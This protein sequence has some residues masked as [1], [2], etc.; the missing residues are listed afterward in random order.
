MEIQVSSSVAGKKVEGDLPLPPPPPDSSQPSADF[1]GSQDSG[2]LPLPPPK[3]SFSK[4]YEQRQVNELKRLYRHMHPELRKNLEEAVSHDLAEIL[5][6][7]DGNQQALLSSDPVVPGEVQSMRWIFENWTLDSIGEHQGLKKL[8]DEESVLSGNVKSTSLQFINQAPS[9][10]ELSNCTTLPDSDKSKGDVHTALWLFETQPLDSLNKMH[11]QQIDVQEAVLREPVARGDVGSAKLL[12]ETCS[13][14]AIGRCKSVE[15]QNLLQLKSEIQE[16]KGDV[17]KT[18]RLF[19]TEPLCAIRDQAGNIHEVKS[20]C[21]EDI[22]SNA[23][24]SVRWLFET[25]PLDTINKDTSAVQLIRGIS[26][27]EAG[28][29]GVNAAKWMFETQPLDTIKERI[30]EGDFQACTE[31][32]SG[33]DVSKHRFLFETQPLDSLKGEETEAVGPK[34]SV[35]GGDVKSTLWLF[36]TQPAKIPKKHFEVGHLQKVELLDAERGDVKQRKNVFETCSLSSIAKHFSDDQ[37]AASD[38]QDIVKGDVK[39]FKNLFETLPL[40]SISSSDKDTAVQEEEIV[41]G[42]VRA[43]QHLFE[44]TPLYAIK[45]S[46]GNFHKVTSVSREQVMSGDVKNYKWMFET[47]PLDQFD[48]SATKVDVIRGITKQEVMAGNVGT[49]KWLFETQPIDVIH[50]KMSKAGEQML[51]KTEADQKGDVMKCR[52]LFE[53]QPVDTLYDKIDTKKDEEPVP[54]ADVKSYTWMF[55]TQPL[56]TLK[57]SEEQYLKVS[58]TTQEDFSGV[59][60]KTTRYLFETEPLN[61]DQSGAQSKRIVRYS[62]RVEMPSG[63]VSRVKEIFESKPAATRMNTSNLTMKESDLAANESIQAGSVNKFT[64]LFENCPMDALANNSEGIQEVLPEKDIKAGDV[65]GKRFVFETYSL[66]QIHEGADGTETREVQEATVKQGAVKSSTMLFETMPL[67]AIQDKEGDYHEVTSVKKEE[68]MKGDVRGAKWLFETK[69]LDSIKTGE[70]VFVIRAVTQEDIQKGDV[71][72]ARWKFETEPLDSFSKESGSVARTVA[73]VQRGDVQSNKQLFESQQVSQKKYVRMVSV[74][75]VQQG[76][77]RTSTWLFENQPI[78]SLKGDAEEES[79]LS[80]VQ[81][82]DNQ[83]GDVKR[84]TWLFETQPMDRLKDCEG[85]SIQATQ[86]VVPPADVKSTTWL[87]ESTPLDKFDS[88][89][90]A[91]NE[92][93]ERNVKDSLDALCSCS[94][95]QDSGIIIEGNEA[96]NVKMAKYKLANQQAP[97]I[98]KEEIVGGNLKRIMQQIL[99]RTNVQSQATLVEENEKGDL[100]VGTMQ[101]FNQRELNLKEEESKQDVS[102]VLQILH[103]QA[104]AIKNGIV[105][106]ETKAGMIKI[107]IYSLLQQSTSR[108][109]QEEVVKGDVKSTIGS[110]LASTQEQKCTSTVKREDNEKGNVQL[111]ATCIE[112]GDLSYLKSLQQ[113]SEINLIDFSQDAVQETPRMDVAQNMIHLERELKGSEITVPSIAPGDI[114]GIKRL[115]TLDNIEQCH[116]TNKVACDSTTATVQPLYQP[117]FVNVA[118]NNLPCDIEAR[119]QSHEIATKNSTKLDAEEHTSRNVREIK[120]VS[121]G[122]LSTKRNTMPEDMASMPATC[123]VPD[124]SLMAPLVED[125]VGSELQAALH[126]LRQA[127]AEAESIQNQVRSKLHKSTEEIHLSSR[128]TAGDQGRV[129]VTAQPVLQQQAAVSKQQARTVA[130]VQETHKSYSSQQKTT[131]VTKKVSASEEQPGQQLGNARQDS[132]IAT[133]ANSSIKDG[134][135]TARP[136]KNFYNPFIED[137]YNEMSLREDVEQDEIVRGDVKAAIRALQGASSEQKALEKEDVVRGN[138]KATLQSLEKSNINVSKGDFKAAM[139]YK[140]AGMSHSICKQSSND[141]EIRKQALLMPMSLSDNDSPPSAAAVMQTVCSGATAK[142][143]AIHQAGNTEVSQGC[144]TTMQNLAPVV[145]KASET[146][147]QAD[148]TLSISA[149]SVPGKKPTLPPKPAHL[150][151]NTG[152]APC[153]D[154]RIRP[155]SVAPLLPP[156]TAALSN[157]QPVLPTDHPKLVNSAVYSEE[158]ER[159]PKNDPACRFPMESKENYISETKTAKNKKTALQIAEEKYRK[160]KEEEMKTESFPEKG[161]QEVRV[162][163]NQMKDFDVAKDCD[164]ENTFSPKMFSPAEELQDSFPPCVEAD[165]AKDDVPYN[166]RAAFSHFE[167]QASS[168]ERGHIATM[169]K[170][171]VVTDGTSVMPNKAHVPETCQMKGAFETS[172]ATNQ[173]RQERVFT[174][175]TSC[176]KQ[177]QESSLQ[178]QHVVCQ[179]NRRLTAEDSKPQNAPHMYQPRAEKQVVIMREKPGRESED[180]RRKRLSVHKDEIMRGNVKAAMDI[181]ENLRKHEELQKILSKVEE[182]EEET[183]TVDVKSLKGLFEN[184][185]NWVVG[186]QD[187]VQPPNVKEQAKV[188]YSGAAKED[189]ESISSVELAFGDLEKASTEITHLKEQTLARLLDIEDAI[190]KAL[191]SVSNLKSE[192]DIAGLSGLFKESLGSNPSPSAINNIRKISIVSSKS[193]P[194]KGVQVTEGRNG[195][196]MKLVEKQEMAKQELEVVNVPPRGSSPV[197]P[198]F[199][200]IESAARRPAELSDTSCCPSGLPSKKPVK[201]EKHIQDNL[202]FLSYLS[203]ECGNSDSVV[204]E[205]EECGMLKQQPNAS[206]CPTEATVQFGHSGTN[207]SSSTPTA[208]FQGCPSNSKRGVSC[209]YKPNASSSPLNPRRQKSVLELKTIPELP[210]VIG[211]TIVT[212]E[213]EEYD[214]FG[215]KIVTSKSSKTVTKQS[216]SKTS[217]T[218]EA[219]STPTRYGVTASPLLRR[220]LHSTGEDYQPNG[221]ANEAGVVFVTFGN[222]SPAKK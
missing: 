159:H 150:V 144:S 110:L 80:T 10:D 217:S 103:N 30:D 140:N 19:Q 120:T 219:V 40:D 24:K 141:Q 6:P 202:S 3:E 18:V 139:I 190:K 67:Y 9:G 99:H 76:N 215:N 59:D 212:E 64:W 188:A 1:S 87:F 11:Q 69:P 174:E 72:A 44:T 22:Q 71:S 95:I 82:E 172:R 85:D 145:S 116:P 23:V 32:V 131:T 196:S 149:R 102:K 169:K 66:D 156:R 108:H 57:E 128:Q 152:R 127:T 184:V 104:A 135:Y 51:A 50:H 17:E 41:P 134:V 201:S 206:N 89:K 123:P 34:E 146:L 70:E 52:W 121:S 143:H 101:L 213:Y 142:E 35:V 200:S 21:R 14:D 54:Q 211:T 93:K 117:T 94:A 163:K 33:A 180:E 61:N 26:L 205:H 186:V 5:N 97:E 38:A 194:E 109:A 122:G 77:V 42:N 203:A 55:E 36:E 125:R 160:R 154:N 118:R 129:V 78:D 86:E 4:F 176:L 132:A 62:S 222:S 37:S 161:H 220:H 177:S 65:G 92:V 53:T 166:F 27:E 8:T 204:R 75:D 173:S 138:L 100:Q 158:T 63:E 83:K 155:T 81:R 20:I 218:Y 198:S 178:T 214:Q 185:P 168:S 130:T 47:K 175:S 105:M 73:D 58:A 126:S 197:S 187:V 90:N 25:Q 192:S 167:N 49:A 15:E 162:A 164:K 133:S 193:K 46:L 106:E 2:A 119:T 111:F 13:L 183:S 207:C 39:C 165:A 179:H 43:N 114:R 68:I 74:S 157:I 79:N 170:G 115:V 96:N 148:Q 137:D 48:E 153:L 28:K 98:Q 171:V 124:A 29:G 88:N 189:A 195:E 112:K 7:D 182:L 181:Y 151:G 91:D 147:G 221:G 216:E 209:D 107:T 208:A 113:D 210:K 16:S 199:I 191:Y 12:F 60:V 136:V 31:S 45:D 56:D 84:C